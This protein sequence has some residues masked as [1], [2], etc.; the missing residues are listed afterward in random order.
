MH[1][2]LC[3]FHFKVLYYAVCSKEKQELPTFPKCAWFY[4]SNDC[5][6]SELD[7]YHQSFDT[8]QWFQKSD[9]IWQ[10]EEVLIWPFCQ[11]RNGVNWGQIL[12]NFGFPWKFADGIRVWNG[13]YHHSNKNPATVMK[14][15][16]PRLTSLHTALHRH[17]KLNRQSKTCT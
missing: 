14:F 7:I 2:L 13:C 8:K 10:I 12:K 4:C 16:D 15:P 6:H 9:K 3:L 1:F 5:K 11:V 17:K